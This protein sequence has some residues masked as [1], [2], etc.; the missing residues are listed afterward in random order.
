M[1][2]ETPTE[3]PDVP[4]FAWAGMHFE[5]RPI[6]PRS[7]NATGFNTAVIRTPVVVRNRVQPMGTATL[8]YC[9]RVC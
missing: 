1:T 2:Q 8:V 3:L 6:A 5:H 7:F 4:C 9:G